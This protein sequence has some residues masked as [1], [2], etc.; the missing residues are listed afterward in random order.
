MIIHVENPMKSTLKN[1]AI[2]SKCI[3]HGWQQTNQFYFYIADTPP[4]LNIELKV[5]FTMGHAINYLGINLTEDVQNPY[6]KN[7]RI[8]LKYYFKVL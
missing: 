7:C 2:T 6:T 1:A 8:L 3:Y 4:K 5:L